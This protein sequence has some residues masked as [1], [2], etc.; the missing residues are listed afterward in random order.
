[1]QRTMFLAGI[2]AAALVGHQAL[3]QA[4]DMSLARLDC[5]TP[6]PPTAVNQRMSDTYSYGDLKIQLVYSC[7]LIKHGNDYLLW[8][9][10]NAITAP[11]VAPKVSLV[12]QLAKINLTPEQ[13][14]YVGISHYHGDHVGQVGSFRKST[15]LIGKG[16]WD[17][18]TS[19]KP[20]EGAVAAP[21]ASWIKGESKVEPVPLDKDV[22]GDGSV[23]M[24]YTP[25]H[26]PGHH[27][28]LVKLPKMGA[29]FISGDLMHFR[30][31]YETNGVPTFNTDRAQTLASLD[32]AKKIVASAKATVIIQHDARDLDKLPVFP[33]SA[34]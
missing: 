13:I 23:I 28:L 20:R 16:D 3:A 29:V 22:F 31:N 9:T 17:E 24:L 33:E 6:N 5:G 7:Y 4:P 34:K 32:R 19:A 27:S 10:G 1:M 2:C 30:E 12:D 8:D 18:L 15:L 14:K 25:G 21:F 26:T 11:N